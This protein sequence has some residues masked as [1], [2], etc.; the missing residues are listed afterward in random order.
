MDTYKHAIPCN[1]RREFAFVRVVIH[2]SL[3]HLQQVSLLIHICNLELDVQNTVCIEVKRAARM[4]LIFLQF[5]CV[6]VQAIPLRY[7]NLFYRMAR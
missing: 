6:R 7:L 2:S 1:T 3:K 5:Y 4:S